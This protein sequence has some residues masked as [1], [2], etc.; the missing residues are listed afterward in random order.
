MAEEKIT[1]KTS[2]GQQVEVELS[3]AKKWGTVKN[4]L[5]GEP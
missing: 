4:M 1:M 3:V 5:E 2:D